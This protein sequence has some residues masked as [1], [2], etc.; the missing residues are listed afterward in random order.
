MDIREVLA[1]LHQKVEGAVASVLVG[2][3]GETID[4]YSED[5]T[6][7]AEWIGARY[8]IV[9][10]DVLGTLKRLNQGEL[11]TIVMELE[12]GTLVILPLRGLFSLMLFLQPQG[13]LGQALFHGRVVA[14]ALEK[15]LVS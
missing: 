12:K 10:R 15:E 4:L 2:S 1:S 5:T 13:N 9:I 7:D 14:L 8:G 11:R 3:D 6:L